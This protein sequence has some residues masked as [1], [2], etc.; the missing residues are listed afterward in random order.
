M[1]DLD[2]AIPLY[3]QLADVLLARIHSGEFAPGSKI[4]S[5]HE[6]A[7]YYKI[8]RPTVR[9]A[10]ELLVRER[11]LERQRGS[12]TFV[13]DLKSNHPI[14][15]FSLTG[16]LSAFDERGLRIEAEWIHEQSRFYSDSFIHHQSPS[17][18]E[19]PPTS[20]TLEVMP[21]SPHPV[22]LSSAIFLRRLIRVDCEP[23]LVEDI[24]L[25][26]TIFHG[27]D[28][29][30]LRD[31]SLSEIVRHQY[32]MVPIRAEQSFQLAMMR[33]DRRAALAIGPKHPVLLVKRTLDFERSNAAIY[34]E[35][36]C[37]TDRFVYSQRIGVDSESKTRLLR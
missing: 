18:N 22:N 27:I 21:Q 8:G 5:E 6:L 37:R 20:P 16:T 23:V 19:I 1:L 13:R 30:D 9:Q 25:D 34:S 12:G 3:R 31:C 4:P 15:L 28:R 14:D 2:S 29:I 33:E 26:Q 11:I 24:W 35:L 10:T 7:R 17:E 36:Y 32:S